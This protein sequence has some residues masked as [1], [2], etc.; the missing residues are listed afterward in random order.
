MQTV[1]ISKIGTIVHNSIELAKFSWLAFNTLAIASVELGQMFR[2]YCESEWGYDQAAF[3][4]GIESALIYGLTQVLTVIS[5]IAV[6]VKEVV[7]EQMGESTVVAEVVEWLNEFKNST[8]DRLSI[9]ISAVRKRT[10]NIQYFH[11]VDP[12]D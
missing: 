12:G 4:S 2:S 3:R 11:E 5:V 9:F 1:Y 6:L 8:E 7:A 10:S